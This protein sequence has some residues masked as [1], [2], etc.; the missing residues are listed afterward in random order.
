MSLRSRRLSKYMLGAA[1]KPSRGSS[2][3]GRAARLGLQGTCGKPVVESRKS[4]LGSSQPAA[5][6]RCNPWRGSR[7]RGFSAS[8]EVRA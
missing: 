2:A 7:G 3:S 6:L 1:V 5:A 8:S 4:R